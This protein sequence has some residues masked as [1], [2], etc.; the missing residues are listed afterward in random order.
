MSELRKLRAAVAALALE[1]ETAELGDEQW[2]DRLW[3][4]L[5]PV[6]DARASAQLTES[7]VTNPSSTGLLQ[8]LDAPY[9][10]PE[11]GQEVK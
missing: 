4:L 8:F 5:D 6:I 10:G 2:Y 9:R 1:P 11:T 3:E 7:A